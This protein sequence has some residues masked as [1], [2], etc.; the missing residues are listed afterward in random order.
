MRTLIL[1]VILALASA[2]ALAPSAA[3]CAWC[4]GSCYSS[5]AC[6]GSCR[7]L[8]TSGSQLGQCVSLD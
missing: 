1:G 6:A 7:C 2:T 4:A 8:K 5:S 3:Q